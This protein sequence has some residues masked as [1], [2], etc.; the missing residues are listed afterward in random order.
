MLHLL[1]TK[2]LLKRDFPKQSTVTKQWC[3]RRFTV[4]WEVET[5]TFGAKMDSPGSPFIPGM[6]GAPV[7]PLIP[8]SPLIPGGPITPCFPLLPGCPITPCE[9][10]LPLLPRSPLSPFG[11]ALPGGPGIPRGQTLNFPCF[12]QILKLSVRKSSK[13]S[14]MNADLSKGVLLPTLRVN[15]CSF[16]SP[17]AF[18]FF[19][20]T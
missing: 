10:F 3:F 9:P 16:I 8:F 2:L 13:T 17:L 11:P 12:G 5:V 14:F 19:F 1:G 6:T 15:L 4:S 18:S 20:R 7:S